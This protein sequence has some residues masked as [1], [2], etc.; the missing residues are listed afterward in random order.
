VKSKIGISEFPIQIWMFGAAKSNCHILKLSKLELSR[1]Q[2]AF[3]PAV[4]ES[5]AITSFLTPE[6]GKFWRLF[7]TCAVGQL[8]V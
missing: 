8:I 1:D 4:F 6:I 3:M 2:T 5:C 7:Y